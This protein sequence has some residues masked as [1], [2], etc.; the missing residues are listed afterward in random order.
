MIEI[1]RKINKIPILDF[2]I[3]PPKLSAYGR[4]SFIRCQL[5]EE[6]LI[7]AVSVKSIVIIVDKKIHLDLVLGE[8]KNVAFFATS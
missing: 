4:A 3:L 5:H 8:T 6:I 1:P 2:H 7:Y